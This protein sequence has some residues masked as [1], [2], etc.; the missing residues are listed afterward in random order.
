MCRL[1]A[2][3]KPAAPFPQRSALLPPLLY[4]RGTSELSRAQHTLLLSVP[5]SLSGSSTSVTWRGT[6]GRLCAWRAATRVPGAPVPRPAPW[7]RQSRTLRQVA[8][9]PRLLQGRW[10]GPSIGSRAGAAGCAPGDTGCPALLPPAS[11]AAPRHC[12]A[13]GNHRGGERRGDVPGEQS[14]PFTSPHPVSPGLSLPF[15]RAM[16]AYSPS[17]CP[18]VFMPRARKTA[19]L[20]A[21]AFSATTQPG[22]HRPRHRLGSRRVSSRHQ[23]DFDHP[24]A[25]GCSG[26]SPAALEEHLEGDNSAQKRP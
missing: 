22:L 20:A 24:E 4:P 3:G 18:P 14:D 1:E 10:L 5:V 21:S 25:A 7:D 16:P 9:Q 17:S 8:A 15:S 23:W 26:T 13:T 6:W 12:A 2:R 19:C 11:P